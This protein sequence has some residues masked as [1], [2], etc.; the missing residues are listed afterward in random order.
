MAAAGR[1]PGSRNG[2]YCFVDGHSD[3]VP[4]ILLHD[5][6]ITGSPG[7]KYIDPWWPGKPKLNN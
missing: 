2:A 4:R 6:S 5:T 7:A 1:R 3:A